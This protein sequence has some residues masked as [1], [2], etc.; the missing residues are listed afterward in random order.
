MNFKMSR[1]MFGKLHEA[2]ESAL[3]DVGMNVKE[4]SSWSKS[5]IQNK[6]KLSDFILPQTNTKLLN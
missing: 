2:K 1:Q 5:K 3:F 4:V 6:R